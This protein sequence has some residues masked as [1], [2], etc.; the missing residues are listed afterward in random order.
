[1][2][3]C[4]PAD[5]AKGEYFDLG[6]KQCTVCPAGTYQ[7]QDSF[8][9]YS[10]EPCDEPKY[11]S[12]NGTDA[13]FHDEVDDCKICP[14]GYAYESSSTCTPCCASG[15][16]D[17]DCAE[18]TLR[19]DRPYTLSDGDNTCLQCP[20]EYVYTSADVPNG[21][22][23]TNNVGIGCVPQ[24]TLSPA[25]TPSPSPA[26]SLQPTLLPS[27]CRCRCRRKNQRRSRRR[28]RRRHQRRGRLTSPR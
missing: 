26:P 2:P 7:A 9:G 20:T 21:E 22:G 11:I 25:P 18:V 24:P 28:G 16:G 6:T 19:A 12:D 3:E 5:C 13:T 15:S 8:P 23:T 4:A 17:G 1:M 10:C 27:S 14:A